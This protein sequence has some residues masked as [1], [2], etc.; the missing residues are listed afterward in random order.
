MK[1]VADDKRKLNDSTISMESSSVAAQVL[2]VT[3][4]GMWPTLSRHVVQTF[5]FQ[6]SDTH[7]STESRGSCWGLVLEERVLRVRA[8]SLEGIRSELWSRQDHGDAHT[9]DLPGKRVA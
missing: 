6:G 9:L 7:S 5:K 8:D 1:Q 2:R 3:G 4:G